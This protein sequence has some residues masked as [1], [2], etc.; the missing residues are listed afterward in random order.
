MSTHEPFTIYKNV[1]IF[2]GKDGKFRA[3]VKGERI[4]R[5][6]LKAIQNFIDKDEPVITIW[7]TS[8]WIN[9]AAFTLMPLQVRRWENERPR[10][11]SGSLGD[12]YTEYYSPTPE[13][14]EK[15]EQIREQ[16]LQLI[17]KWESLKK[18]IKKTPRK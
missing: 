14:V 9:Q 7:Q 3:T 16:Y 6:S 18:T 15:A 1:E 10:L 8:G 12:R 13:Q 2:V 17:D 11:M 4:T 5:A